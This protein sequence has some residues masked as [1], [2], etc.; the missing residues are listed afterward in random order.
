MDCANFYTMKPIVASIIVAM[1]FIVGAVLLGGQDSNDAGVGTRDNV[2]I[3][4][5]KQI[6]EITA[7]GGYLPGRTVAKAG[8]PTALKINTRGTFDCS[9]AISIPSLGY[10][11]N[12]PPSA[13]TIIDIPTQSAGD[14]LTGICA[15]GMYSFKVDFE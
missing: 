8:M 13:E 5:G 3:V 6:I 12:L 11:K 4:D 10:R 7:K 1:L 15:M 2:S 9:A 14:S